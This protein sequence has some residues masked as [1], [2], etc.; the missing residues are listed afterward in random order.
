MPFTIVPSCFTRKATLGDFL[1]EIRSNARPNALYI[2]N[3]NSEDHLSSCV[4][5]GN[6]CIRPFNKHGRGL[7]PRSAGVVTG[8]G[9]GYEKLS[10][11]SAYSGRTC[12]D[13]I[14]ECFSEIEE[15]LLNPNLKYEEIL[16][17]CASVSDD[18]IGTSIFQVG[19]EV[20]DYIKSKIF[21]LADL[22]TRSQSVALSLP[23]SPASPASPPV[24]VMKTS[25]SDTDTATATTTGSAESQGAKSGSKDKDSSS[26]STSSSGS[27]SS[28]R[29]VCGDVD[30]I[31]DTIKKEKEEG[32]GEEGGS[33]VTKSPDSARKRG[34]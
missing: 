7:V 24:K 12:Q 6:A 17:S 34:R 9:D 30:T 31:T 2:F 8:D 5:G 11:I 32:G 20:K 14:D 4:G 29:G 23:L 27:S 1:W 21:A 22:D 18:S 33:D 16:Y 28:S 25:S 3:D 26:S 15:L 13:E 10:S 19:L